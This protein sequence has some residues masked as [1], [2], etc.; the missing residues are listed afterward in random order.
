MCILSDFLV[1]SAIIDIIDERKNKFNIIR[2]DRGRNLKSG[3]IMVQLS[4]IIQCS[5]FK[6]SLF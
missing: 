2:V 5:A 6:F 1:I 4:L 3:R